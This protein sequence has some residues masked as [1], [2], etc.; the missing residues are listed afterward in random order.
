VILIEALEAH[1]LRGTLREGVLKMFNG[2]LVILKDIQRNNLYYLKDSTVT[3]TLAASERLDGD[4]IRLW[5]SRLDM[6]V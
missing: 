6:L 5:H 3:E 1:D 4:F 2:P